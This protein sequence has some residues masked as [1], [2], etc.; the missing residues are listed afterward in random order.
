MEL[1]FHY[2]F[3]GGVVQISTT[4]FF[5]YNKEGDIFYFV[6]LSLSIQ[7]KKST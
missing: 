6:N 4:P 5:V 2:I 1:N 3:L 7:F